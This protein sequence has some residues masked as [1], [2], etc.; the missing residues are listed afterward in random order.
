MITVISVL[1]FSSEVIA[2]IYS[3]FVI[4]ILI[5]FHSPRADQE[6]VLYG[7]H[8]PILFFLL[9]VTGLGIA[10][11]KSELGNW[12]LYYFEKITKRFVKVPIP[13]VLTIT[14]IPLSL[15]LPSSITRNAMLYPLM[16]KYVENEKQ[17]EGKRVFLI[18]GLVNPMASS[19][20]LTG[21][22]SAIVAAGLIGGISWRNWFLFMAFPYYL[23][24]LVGLLYILFR[25]PTPQGYARTFSPI[26]GPKE[27]KPLT[28]DDW[29]ILS[30]MLFVVI[31]WIT[32]HW[33]FLHPAVPALVGLLI[34]FLF[35][36]S[37][38]WTDINASSVWENVIIIGT[39]LSLVEALN[40]YGSFQGII[41]IIESS[42]PTS[43]NEYVIILGCI[44]LTVIF[45]LFI[46]NITVCI[47]FLIPL[48]IELSLKL[49]MNP[50]IMALLTAMTIDCIKFYPT[51]STPLLMVYDRSF[52][53]VRD[54]FQM[55]LALLVILII[56]VYV[57]ILPYWRMIGV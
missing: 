50:V 46:P 53:S 25:Y 34:L 49:G 57:I 20:F 18:L 29:I 11:S 44:L 40:R 16:K 9:A 15:L 39:F 13:L 26:H 55:G 1:L 4:M 30:T 7:F 8:S 56:L 12:F 48:F 47:T 54:V 31:F 14:F 24:M 45:N 41:D 17:W 22:L 6:L 5:F 3:S 38:R 37:L 28:K 42:L 10:I 32:D 27:K 35:T 51:Q 43:L 52:F 36:K 33:H 21:G 23:M 2:P 19:A